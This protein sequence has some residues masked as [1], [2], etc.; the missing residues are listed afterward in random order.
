MSD[1]KSSVS[2]EDYL[3]KFEIT[4]VEGW[5]GNYKYY[6]ICSPTLF[7]GKTTYLLKEGVFEYGL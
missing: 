2:L 7:C 1:V 4:T 5:W 3:T 6:S